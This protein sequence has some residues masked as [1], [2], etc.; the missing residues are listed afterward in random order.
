MQKRVLPMQGKAAALP[1]DAGANAL[2]SLLWAI[3][4]QARAITEANHAIAAVRTG[5]QS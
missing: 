2:Y 3:E 1:I 5:G 4:E